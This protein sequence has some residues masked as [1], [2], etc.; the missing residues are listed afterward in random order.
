VFES[1]KASIWKEF[2]E[3]GRVGTISGNYL[4]RVFDGGLTEKEKRTSV[5]HVIQGTATYIFKRALL[6]LSK[7]EGVDVLIPMHDAVL[8]QHTDQVEPEKAKVIFE[9]VMTEMLPSITGKA[10]LEEFYVLE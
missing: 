6:E 5:N 4:N 2:I 3:N 7:V 9:G 1:W 10:S 8:I